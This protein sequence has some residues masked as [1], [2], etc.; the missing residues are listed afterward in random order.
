MGVERSIQI[1]S[2]VNEFLAEISK[3]QIKLIDLNSLAQ[4]LPNI[5]QLYLPS[6]ESMRVI[7][8]KVNWLWQCYDALDKHPYH[9]GRWKKIE[10]LDGWNCLVRC[11]P[12]VNASERETKRYFYL[13]SPD[14][15]FELS[16]EEALLWQFKLSHDYKNEVNFSYKRQSLWFNGWL[17]A[18]IYQWLNQQTTSETIRV[19]M[20]SNFPIHNMQV[21]EIEI[22]L[23]EKL[24][25]RVERVL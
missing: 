15:G 19:E 9:A 3:H 22:V 21:P 17:P 12:P 11:S 8:T 7:T 13:N 25:V 1:S 24:G 6:D 2:N 14:R 10:S 4:R 20:Q 5:N 16:R 18:S 23:V